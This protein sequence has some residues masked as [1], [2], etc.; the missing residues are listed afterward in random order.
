MQRRYLMKAVVGTFVTGVVTACAVGVRRTYAASVTGAARDGAGAAGIGAGA[1]AA[2]AVSAVGAARV[3]GAASATDAPSHAAT[4]GASTHGA[5]DAVAYRAQRRFANLRFGKIAYLDRGVGPR[6]ALFLHGFPLNSF[7]WRGAI[8][9]LAT[10]RRC[11]APDFMALGY[12]EVADGQ[13]CA[14][15]AQAEMLAALLDS[16][17]IS[18]VDVIASDSGGAVAQIFMTRYPKRVRT[19]LLANCDTEPDS[20]PLALAPVLKSARRGKFADE[21]LA[22]GLADK[23]L[24]RSAKG[25][26][27][28]CYSM[29]TQPTDEAIEYYWA[30]VCSSPRRKALVD[31]YALALTPNPLAGIE[32]ALKRST[33]PTRVV[34]GMADDIFAK[35][36]ADYLDRT[37]GNSR[38]VRRLQRAKLFWPEEYPDIVAEEARK[39]WGV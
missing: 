4:S 19:L 13:S 9:R 2:A 8:E 16:L 15:V 28:A 24:A 18:D 29:P 26:G 33:V 5:L 31:A 22:P 37:M 12:T 35:D 14:P 6:A 32:P 3:T 27:G 21:W 10:N 38:G 34:W 17:S 36:S 23:E 30:P 39:L 11:I 20:P 25:I 1:G 7:Q